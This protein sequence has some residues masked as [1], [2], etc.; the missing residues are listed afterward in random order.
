M[1]GPRSRHMRAMGIVGRTVPVKNH[2]AFVASAGL[3]AQRPPEVRF[4]FVGGGELEQTI[5]ADVDRRGL[6]DRTHFLGW[7]RDLPRIYADLDVVA[8]SFVNEG[9]PVSLIEAMAAGAPVVSTAVGGPRRGHAP[10]PSAARSST[11]T[12]PSACAGTSSVSM[13]GC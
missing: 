8:L 13:T 1:L 12:G 7:R 5:P 11:N 6:T 10:L 3:L 9:T 2:A 4:V